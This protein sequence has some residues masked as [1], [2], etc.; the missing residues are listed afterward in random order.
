[1]SDG[2][3]QGIRV[4][5][6]GRIMAGPVCGLMLADLGA[7]V[8]KIEMLPRGDPSRRFLP[9][10]VGGESAAFM[11]LNRNKRGVAI[12]VSNE[13]G[14]DV[15]RRLIQRADVLVE[16]FRGDRMEQLGL[17]FDALRQRNPGL[18]WCA[19]S[20]FGRT[21]PYARR[22]GFDLTAQGYSG[23][24]SITGEGE[25]RPP[26]KMGAPVTDITAG[27][28]GAVGVLAAYVQR[29][30]TG[31][32]QQVDTS[33]FEAGIVQTYWQSA[34]TLATD[35]APGAMGTAHPL[36]APYE[37]FECADGWITLGASSQTTWERVPAVL[38]VPEL[39][40][41]SRFRENSD[42]MKHRAELAEILGARFKRRSVE[43]WLCL[44]DEAQV[45]AGPV[46]DVRAMLAHEQTLARQMVVDVEHTRIGTVK[47]LG[48]PLKFSGANT[49]VA[50][51]APLLGEHT[52]EVL[53]EVGYP[54]ADVRELNDM[55]VVRIANG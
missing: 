7:D 35:V 42:R 39:L 30:R 24:M 5:E 33:L 4:V 18:I 15:V 9:P 25:D 1:M 11:M 51:A 13:T 16:N 40:E 17:G 21:G 28:L 54:D 23:L 26:V 6:F 48:V 49:P 32:G 53:Q 37:A 34:I 2:P 43:E 31:E 10:D 50:R 46:L 36:S 45:P 44:L 52:L 12:D 19:I 27:I 22:G 47:T 8:V 55:G 14:K 41:D 3:L 38:E 20:G 29:V